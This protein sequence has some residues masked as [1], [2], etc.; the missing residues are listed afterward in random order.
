MAAFFHMHS[1]FDWSR[2]CWCIEGPRRLDTLHS[3]SDGGG[4]GAGAGA[5]EGQGGP[6][7][8]GAEA[9]DGLDDSPA[10]LLLSQVGSPCTL[11][12]SEYSTL[13]RIEVD[14]GVVTY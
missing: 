4:S 12:S 5:G 13:N 10:P 7:V 6:F 1:H 14:L 11:L 2:Y 9:F 3:H 8:H